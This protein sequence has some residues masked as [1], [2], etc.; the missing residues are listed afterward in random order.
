MR[1][2]VTAGGLELG[3]VSV[4]LLWGR[5]YALLRHTS[6]NPLAPEEWLEL[7]RS[8]LDHAC[9]QGAQQVWH[10]LIETADHAEISARLPQLAFANR[11]RRLEFRRELA[12]LPSGAGSPLCWRSAADLGWAPEAVAGLLS[13]VVAGDPGHDPAEDP[14]AFIADWLADPVL[15]AGLG[16]VGIGYIGEDVAALAVAQINPKTLW[17]RIS[18]MGVLPAFRGRGFGAWVHRQ[19][20]DMLRAQG[21]KLYHGGTSAENMPMLALFARHGVTP[22]R[23]MEEW[24]FTTGN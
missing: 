17:S 15:T 22:Y 24:V 18:Y 9:A 16:C 11:G 14:L 1:F 23:S 10:R 13:R 20:F 5:V 21:G 4:S 3:A 19:G 6:E 2:S 8:S 12:E 7:Y